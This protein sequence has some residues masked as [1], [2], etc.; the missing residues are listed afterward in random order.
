MLQAK[1]AETRNFIA[2]E[3]PKM[4]LQEAIDV[5]MKRY[6]VTITVNDRAFKYEQIVDVLS[7]LVAEQAVPAFT[8]TLTQMLAKVLGKIP[9]PSGA[10]YVVRGNTIEITTALF[11]EA[12]FVRPSA[13]SED[14]PAVARWPLV[15]AAIAN[16]PLTEA[17]RDLSHTYTANVVVDGRSAKEAATN[18]TADFANVPF[19]TAVKLLADMCGLSTV[20]I[21]NV[22]YVT[23]E[24]ERE[25]VAS[26]A[27]KT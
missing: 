11:R 17:L 12:E 26:G 21:G 9:C 7:T 1:L 24:G 20:E 25:G 6:D 8:G 22:I 16:T 18:V 23:F 14:L 13:G 4:T 10:C 2:F 27:G 5:L 19:D 3:D 15:H